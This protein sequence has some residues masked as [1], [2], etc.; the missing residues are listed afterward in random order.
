MMGEV[1]QL[2]KTLETGSQEDVWEAAK[3]LE[4][5]V[6]DITLSLLRLLEESERPEARAAA[7][8]VLGFGRFASARSSLEQVVANVSENAF[9]RGHA[10]E[11][12]A[13][14]RS[15]ESVDQLLAQLNDKDAGVKYW[16]IFA[17]R[18]IGDPKAIQFLR[19]IADSAEDDI[20]EG[21]SLRAEAL[22]ALDGIEQHGK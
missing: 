15:R 2:L 21:H 18:E 7:A 17:L 8:Y 20:Y 4:S 12:L 1:S 16:C 13:Y 6:V 11:A 22:A 5:H 3:Q 10:A 19:Q 14:I 9:V